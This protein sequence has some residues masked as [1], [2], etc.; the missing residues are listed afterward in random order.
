MIPFTHLLLTLFVVSVW[1]FNFVVIKVGL[2]EVSP[3]VL[4]IL[5][6]FFT[7]VPAIFFVERPQV[8]FKTIFCYGLLAFALHFS[9]L[10]LGIY[11][12][13]TPGL[14]SLVVQSQIIF[15]IAFAYLFFGEKITSRQ[16]LGSLFACAGIAVIGMNTGG[17]V[18]FMGF[19]FLSAAAFFWSLGN[20]LS[21]TITKVNM[22]AFV[23]WCSMF[24]W[25]P[26]L[27][28]ALFVEGVDSFSDSLMLHQ[29]SWTS[30]AAIGYITY[31][32]TLFGYGCWNFLM[33]RYAV[34]KIAPF[35]LLVPI[36]GMVSSTLMLGESLETWKILA[37]LLIVTGIAINLWKKQEQTVKEKVRAS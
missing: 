12:G 14:A 35:T 27:L 23:I 33:S 13:V 2:E 22:I 28:V 9:F 1:G 20:M 26:I 3:L 25:P 31:L 30:L 4:T 21:K 10:F 32:S 15:S 8:P 5:R 18:T 7:S 37:A 11:S 36:I 34:S 6:L 17:S 24:T 29:L 16:I 19:L